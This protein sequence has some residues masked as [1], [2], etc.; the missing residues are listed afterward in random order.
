VLAAALAGALPLVVPD[1]GAVAVGLAVAP[2]LGDFCARAL[3]VV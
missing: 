3:E 1:F 2:A